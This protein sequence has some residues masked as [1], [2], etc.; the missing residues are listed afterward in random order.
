MVKLLLIPILYGGLYYNGFQ[1]G[2]LEIRRA[3]DYAEVRDES[4]T[5]GD[6]VHTD[7]THV[8]DVATAVAYSTST[9]IGRGHSNMRKF[10]Q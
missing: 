5:L 9:Q 7:L 2:P 3:T 4:L 8:N 1:M 6:G 10:T